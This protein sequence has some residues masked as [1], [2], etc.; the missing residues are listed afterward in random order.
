M[1][2]FDI[3]PDDGEPYRVKASS[4]DVLT[5]EKALKGRSFGELAENPTMEGMYGLAYAAARRQGLCHASLTLQQFE[6]S[7]DLVLVD[8]ESGQPDPTQAGAGPAASSA[9]QSPPASPRRSGSRK[10]NAR[11]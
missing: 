8:D 7:V 4:R 9:S 10:T 5:W 3:T 6:T 11:S 2:T 1:F